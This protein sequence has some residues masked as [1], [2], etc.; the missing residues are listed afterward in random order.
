MWNEGRTSIYQ[1]SFD[2]L[3]YVVYH[4]AFDELKAQ[5]VDGA[6]KNPDIPYRINSC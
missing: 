4:Y 6:L 5:V 3:K 1:S 2:I